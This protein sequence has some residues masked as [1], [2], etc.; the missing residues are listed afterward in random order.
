[1]APSP[2]QPEVETRM[3]FPAPPNVH[4]GVL[5]G[6][7]FAVAILARLLIPQGYW[8]LASDLAFDIWA[9]YL[10]LWIRRIEPAAMSLLWCIAYIALQITFSVPTAPVQTNYGLTF[11]AATLA[12]LCIAMWFIT[13]YVIRAELHFHYN[14]R[15]PVGLY[16]SGIMTFFF[17]F[18]YFQYHLY[19]IAQL[20]ERNGDRP[21]YYQASP[22]TLPD[23]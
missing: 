20:R 10:C 4:W 18:L 23:E 3:V 14:L 1:M 15:E 12:L 9:I 21:F 11:F 22:L 16:L 19:K 7:L 2:A 8:I 5:L 17:S 6:V 13:V